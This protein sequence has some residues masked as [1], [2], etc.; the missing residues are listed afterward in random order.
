M[1]VKLKFLNYFFIQFYSYSIKE[2]FQLQYKVSVLF[3][4]YCELLPRLLKERSG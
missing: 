1:E 4:N 2:K 3:N